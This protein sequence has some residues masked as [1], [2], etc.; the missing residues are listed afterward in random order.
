MIASLHG[1]LI[2]KDL[3]SAVVECGGVG[4]KCFVTGITAA[5]LPALGNEVFLYT[6]LSVRED[7]L[8]LY[9]FLTAQEMETFKLITSVNGVGAKIGLALLSQFQSDRLLL[10]IAGNDAKSLTA[11]TGVGIKLAQRIVLELKDKVGVMAKEQGMEEIA[12]VGNAVAASNT[13]EAIEAL[14]S[15]GFSQSEASLAVGRL[16]PALP[17]DQLIKLALK[18]LSRRA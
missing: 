18:S 10:L 13:G 12:A 17:T 1:K 15:L 2:A 14:A 3:N 9:G 6:F 5:S 11:A 7:A 8:D 16:D 4:M